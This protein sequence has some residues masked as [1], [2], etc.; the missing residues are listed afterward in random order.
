[1][2]QSFQGVIALF[3]VVFWTARIL[4]DYDRYVMTEDGRLFLLLYFIAIGMGIFFMLYLAVKNHG[5]RILAK[6]SRQRFCPECYAHIGKEK[7]FCP[8]CGANLNGSGYVT[9][10]TYCNTRILDADRMFCPKCGRELK[11]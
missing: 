4:A 1:M 2:R 7:E 9:Y 6:I 8:K 5:R 3:W 10:C 11:K